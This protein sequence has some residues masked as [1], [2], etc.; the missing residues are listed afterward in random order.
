MTSQLFAFILQDAL[1]W[2]QLIQFGPTVVLLA[3]ILW[4]LARALPVWK[5]LRLKEMELRSEE[6]VVKGQ[7]AVA[8]GQ[9]AGALTD[10]AVEQRRATEEVKILQ[11]VNA[12]S[13]DDLTHSVRALTQRVDGIQQRIEV[14]SH[15]SEQT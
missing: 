3:L 7:Q 12:D 13:A 2:S 10:I 5:E 4:F 15:Q 9:L 1:A 6:S 11:R 14:P 8:L